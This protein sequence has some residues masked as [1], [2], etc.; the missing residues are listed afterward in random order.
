MTE[1]NLPIWA[2]YDKNFVDPLYRPYQK[3]QVILSGA[4]LGGFNKDSPRAPKQSVNIYPSVPFGTVNEGFNVRSELVRS[5]HGLSFQKQF[6]S[7]PCPLMWKSK[8]DG[9]CVRTEPLYKGTMYTEYSPT[10]HNFDEKV[11][12]LSNKSKEISY[13][14]REVKY[15]GTPPQSNYGYNM[16]KFG[17]SKLPSRDSYLS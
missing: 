6:D 8:E 15:S 13:F 7:D 4:Q 5:G 12:S 3:E 10:V 1:Y 17:Y 16:M 2:Y 11:P 9:W 14:P